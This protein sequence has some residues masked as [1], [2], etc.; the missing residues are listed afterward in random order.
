[1]A[2]SGADRLSALP[3]EVLHHV[4]SF[5]P[6]HEVLPTSRLA[7]RWRDLWKS[8]PA[9]RVTGVADC[10]N[11]VWFVNYVD[12]LLLLRDPGARLDAFAIDLDDSDFDFT[13]LF[14][15]Y[16]STVNLW[17]RHALLCRARALSLRTTVGVYIEDDD[18]GPLGLPDAPIVSQ[19]LER[20]DLEMVTL[21]G[22]ALDFSGCPALVELKM[23]GCAILG[24]ISSSS[25]SL[26]HLSLTDCLM[27]HD[28][29]SR[30]RIDSPSLVSL[31]LTGFNGWTPVLGN[32]PLLASA[33]VRVTAGCDDMCCKN[34]Y[35]DCDDGRCCGCNGHY[36]A[37]DEGRGD[38]MLLK[39]LSQ[40]TELEL[41]VDS[42]MFIVNGDL[43]LCTTFPKLKTL[44]LSEWCPGI[45]ADL[46]MLA[47]FLRQ[48]PIL[49]KLTLE[50]SKVPKVRV[51]RERRFQ[52]FDEQSFACNLLKKVEI[53]CEVDGRVREALSILSSCGIPLTQFKI[54]HG[55]KASGR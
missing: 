14:P 55:N 20:L 47:C 16:D 39:G 53:K 28:D 33:I 54:Q 7:R 31:V 18:E 6:A 30:P 3:D 4:L 25:P 37:C 19:D 46:N 49:E 36:K 43:E 10:L 45:A 5:L 26:K 48:S 11:P 17:F 13:P 23:K 29:F 41:S 21:K 50:I 1:M 8:A 2:A 34:S 27:V 42:N 40:V 24:N 22:R 32:M 44:L 35:G 9:L 51:Q 15:T 12:N 52:R 38:S